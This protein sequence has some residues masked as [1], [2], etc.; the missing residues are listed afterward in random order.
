MSATNLKTDEK[1]FVARAG[2]HGLRPYATPR[3][4]A[5]GD[6]RDITLG[7]SP[8]QGDSGWGYDCENEG[9]GGPPSC[10]APNYLKM[11]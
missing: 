1:T 7:G 6:I 4:E 10:D 2:A 11:P 9:V 8:G 3:L 5:L